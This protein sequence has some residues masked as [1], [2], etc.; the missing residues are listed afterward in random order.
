MPEVGRDDGPCRVFVQPAKNPASHLDQGGC[1]AGGQI[2]APKQLLTRRLDGALQFQERFAGRMLTVGIDPS[3]DEA[4]ISRKLAG[5][6]S[7][8]VVQ[9]G[10]AEGLIGRERF[11]RETLTG[12]IAVLGKED[13]AA[14]DGPP[15]VL[16]A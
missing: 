12:N 3:P 10:A 4:R 14:I 7:E 15:S 13:V 9:R 8:K 2:Q 5:Q 1:P 6:E 11:I 16:G